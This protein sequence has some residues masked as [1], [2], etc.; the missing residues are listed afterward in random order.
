ML[1]KATQNL[2]FIF[3]VFVLLI[4][5][6]CQKGV[7]IDLN[8]PP[9][10]PDEV[11]D[12]TLLIKSLKVVGGGVGDKD[13]LIEFYSYDTVNRK[14]TITWQDDNEDFI[15]NGSK[16]E[17]SY[18]EKGLLIQAQYI[19]PAGYVPWDFD[20][21]T[22]DLSYDNGNVLQRVTSK[23]MNGEVEEFVFTKTVHADGH[24][25]LTWNSG[26]INPGDSTFRKVEF[27]KNGN[28]I[29][30]Y[31]ENHFYPSPGNPE[32]KVSYYF[33][34][35]AYNAAGEV[36]EIFRR[37]NFPDPIPDENFTFYEF[38]SRK[39]KGDQ[40]YNHRQVL[41]NGIANIPFWDLDVVATDGFGLLSFLMDYENIQ[42]SK[43]PAQMIRARMWDGTFE[44]F[45]VV[46]ELDNKDRLTKFTG[47]FQDYELEPMEY[48]IEYYK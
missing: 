15:G 43:T 3:S 16:A 44:N 4:L 37:K 48:T 21:N 41:L 26:E 8:N 5:T 34:S 18:N 12:S 19:Y 47:F 22:I 35:L 6:S 13:S 14:I 28:A 24:Y 29:T 33:D 27:D 40:L 31:T 2:L 36:E 9:P 7:D 45:T 42:Y 11:M 25:R 20:Y 38:S 17:L 1:T 30:S 23:Y 39:T 46:S 10:I 32:R